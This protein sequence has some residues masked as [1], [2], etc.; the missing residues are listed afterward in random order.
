MPRPSSLSTSVDEGVLEDAARHLYS[1]LGCLLDLPEELRNTLASV[2][3]EVH[4]LRRKK[5]P[6]LSL[7]TYPDKKT[8]E[9]Y[10][11]WL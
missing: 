6:C 9:N 5:G 3:Y 10:W 7:L 2:Y 11:M 8:R 1:H 4:W